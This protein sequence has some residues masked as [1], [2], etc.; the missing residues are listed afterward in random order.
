MSGAE[1]INGMLLVIVPFLPVVGLLVVMLGIV[2]A[3]GRS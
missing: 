2:A 1:A 3:V